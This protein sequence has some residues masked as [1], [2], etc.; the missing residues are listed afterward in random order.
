MLLI[1]VLIAEYIE[2]EEVAMIASNFSR[3][4]IHKVISN[5]GDYVATFVVINTVN[6]SELN[7]VYIFYD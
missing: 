5:F 6:H 1:N 7:R 2:G 4:R 3:F